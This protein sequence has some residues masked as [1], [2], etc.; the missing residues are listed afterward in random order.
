MWLLAQTS[1][2]D[3][4]CKIPNFLVHRVWGDEGLDLEPELVALRLPLAGRSIAWK[5][6]ARDLG[7]DFFCPR[8]LCL[9]LLASVSPAEKGKR[10]CLY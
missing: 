10:D 8:S 2:G 9:F 6:D 5:Q 1:L 4:G 3:S 7:S